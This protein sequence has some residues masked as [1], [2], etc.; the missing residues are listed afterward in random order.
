MSQSINTIR[1]KLNE[2]KWRNKYELEKVK[3]YYL[4]RGA[5]NDTKIITGDTIKK[6]GRSFIK[7]EES[8][9]PYHRVF[10]ITYKGKTLMKREK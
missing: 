5:P 8:T 6:I 9:I 4:H 7:T 1:N 10:K 2:I 3:L